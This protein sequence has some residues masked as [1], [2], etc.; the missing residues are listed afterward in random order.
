[1]LALRVVPRKLAHETNEGHKEF[2]PN[3]GTV[4]ESGVEN[5]WSFKFLIVFVLRLGP[6]RLAHETSEGHQEFAP[7]SQFKG[8][9]YENSVENKW[10]FKF[11]IAFVVR[12]GLS[13]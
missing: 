1:M 5:E 7:N 6:Q 3:K 11:F 2:A 13:P 9:V 4:Y 8:M 10:S 12:V